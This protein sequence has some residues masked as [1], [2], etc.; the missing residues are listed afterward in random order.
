VPYGLNP[1]VAIATLTFLASL[2]SLYITY[3]M[4]SMLHHWTDG[5][6]CWDDIDVHAYAMPFSWLNLQTCTTVGAKVKR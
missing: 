1:S 4:P 3:Q 5:P 6:S 2:T